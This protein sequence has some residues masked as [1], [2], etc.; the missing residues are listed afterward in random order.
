MRVKKIDG[1]IGEPKSDN[2]HGCTAIGFYAEY[3]FRSIFQIG[4]RNRRTAP[5]TYESGG[6][7]NTAPVLDYEALPGTRVR[8]SDGT[9]AI[10]PGKRMS[11]LG[12]GRQMK[13]GY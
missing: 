6:F 2:N 10:Y 12:S 7:G 11:Q 3:H 8:R 4:Q 1:T 9:V 5:R 13:R